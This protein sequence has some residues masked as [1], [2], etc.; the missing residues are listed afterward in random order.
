MIEI[1]EQDG[2]S[3]CS[4]VTCGFQVGYICWIGRHTYRIRWLDGEFTEQ[5]RPDADEMFSEAAQ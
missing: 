4:R 3:L 5:L 2:L 1:D